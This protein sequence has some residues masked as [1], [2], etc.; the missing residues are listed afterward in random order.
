MSDRQ[1]TNERRAFKRWPADLQ[2]QCYGPSGSSQAVI[3]EISEAGL[4]LTSDHPAQVD[5]ELT[6]A[7]V[8]DDGPPLQIT[9]KV[10]RAHAP[11]TGV[12]F[13]DATLADRVRI[14][15]YL[16]TRSKVL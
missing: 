11:V 5:E 3:V 16:S 14:V 9:C 4:T 7:W 12:E 13:L 10:R 15:A 1:R 2:S 6:V 8:L